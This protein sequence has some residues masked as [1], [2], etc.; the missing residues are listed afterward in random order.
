MELYLYK[1]EGM[2][3]YIWNQGARAD[4]SLPCCSKSLITQARWRSGGLD[5]IRPI[6]FSTLTCH[7]LKTGAGRASQVIIWRNVFGLTS[8]WSMDGAGKMNFSPNCIVAH[9]T[10]ESTVS[11][12][13]DC[14]VQISPL[15]NTVES[16]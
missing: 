2:R 12:A 9:N 5:Y 14:T 13:G 11:D 7:Y 6:S 16:S 1:S 15:S 8:S 4:V 10:V 3:A